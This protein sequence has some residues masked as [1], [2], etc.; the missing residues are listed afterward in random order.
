LM[1]ESI[2]EIQVECELFFPV[3]QEYR[4]YDLGRETQIQRKE[5]ASE[6]TICYT[7]MTPA[8]MTRWKSFIVK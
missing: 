1:V 6:G 4:I 5:A 3:Q 2:E 8:L 7:Q